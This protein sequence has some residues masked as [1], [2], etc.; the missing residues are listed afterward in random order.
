M[1]QSRIRQLLI[2]GAAVSALVLA[3]CTSGGENVDSPQPTAG[4][5]QTAGSGPLATMPEFDISREQRLLEGTWRYMPGAEQ[6]GTVL[7]VH[8]TGAKIL[9]R[10]EEW[11]D[12][13]VPEY[14]ASP[15]LNIYGTH[16]EMQ[17]G[18]DVGFAARLSAIDGAATISFHSKPPLRY[19]E[20]LDR[21]PGIDVT[22]DGRAAT[23]TSCSDICDAADPNRLMV[24]KLELPEN[25]GQADITLAQIGDQVVVNVNG[26]PAGING[27]LFDNQVW[28]GA[29]AAG[30][31][32]VDALNA[33]PIGD[34]QLSQVDMSQAT[35]GG[36][37]RSAD[38]LATTTAEN[39][40]DDVKIG[41][42]VDMLS[43][44]SN[45]QYAEF[46]VANFNSIETEMLAKFQALQPERGQYEF[47]ELDALVD[48]ANRHGL[49][50]HGHAL[51]FGE[52]YPQWLHEALEG[53]SSAES[54]E[55][56]RDHITTVVSRYNGQSGHGE[57]RC[58]DVVNEPFDA[59][60]WNAL[61]EGNIWY[62]AL[63]AE[64]IVDAFKF[65]RE[66][67]PNGCFG[68]NEW[69]METDDDRWAGM[70]REI[71][72]L[73]AAG[74]KPD[75]I[76]FQAH[77]DEDTL[78]DDEAMQLVFDG[79]L[80]ERFE[81]LR[82]LGI[83][84]HVSELSVALSAGDSG[85]TDPAMQA[86]VYETVFRACL[87]AENCRRFNLWGATSADFYFTSSPGDIGDDA[88]TVMDANGAI[89]PRPA[90]EALK[91][92]SSR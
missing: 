40:Y 75:F 2:T 10:H 3:G 81:E 8:H 85:E 36:G 46:V 55:L 22:V 17:N 74:Q 87:E 39:G 28:F 54:R 53:A 48:F 56:L 70:L 69:G 16:V 1:H 60:D 38:G 23:I 26:V 61:N 91:Q 32:K 9:K 84:V 37:Q 41:T 18:S 15:Q 4:V 25:A 58:W 20:R 52:A 49:E 82:K 79:Q 90:W 19:D 31:F 68:M 47:A 66:A 30:S 21:M 88:P 73:T 5:E 14:I 44:L 65:A 33:Y 12:P 50:V 72:V 67:N 43:L 27:R 24:Q 59:D 71:Q 89:V 42:A 78:A 92:A 64:Y 63:G 7:K 83:D 62:R 57:I 86:R 11:L 51:V 76:G 13:A 80:A 35:F 6:E 29:D 77:F 45:P 34:V